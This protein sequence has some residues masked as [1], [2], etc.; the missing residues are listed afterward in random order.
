MPTSFKSRYSPSPVLLDEFQKLPRKIGNQ[1][2]TLEIERAEEFLH[3][4]T[5]TVEPARQRVAEKVAPF[6]K[7]DHRRADPG[8]GQIQPDLKN[9]G[10]FRKRLAISYNR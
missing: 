4:Q 10:V 7:D 1:D 6:P 9:D 8:L 5:V 2:D 3:E